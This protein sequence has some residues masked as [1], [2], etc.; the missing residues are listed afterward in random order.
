MNSSSRTKKPVVLTN[1]SSASS[2]DISGALS[3][4]FERYGYERPEQFV[5]Q[6]ADMGAMMDEMRAAKGDLLVSYG[7]DGTAAAVASIARE[8]NLPFIA[9]PGGTM[10]MLMLGLYG[11]DIW[12]ECLLRAL[13][14][15][16]PRPMTVGV[17]RDEQGQTGTFMVGAMFGKPT[18]MSAA[19][20]DLRDGNVV[21]AAKGA[22]DALKATS[23]GVAIDIARQGS[24]YENRALELI[25]VTCPFMDGEAL[26]PERLDLTLF[27]TI[28]GGS[29]LSLGFSA[30]RGNLRHSQVVETMKSPKFRLRAGGTID[31]LLDG[32]PY[33]FDG[34]VSVEIDPAHGLVLAPWPAMASQTPTR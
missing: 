4:I 27:E 8:Q 28:T 25:N 21:E 32:E 24:D 12:E 16:K 20:E 7:G 33:I 1:L 17:V 34:D 15:A 13:A 30:L 5:G 23:D 9:L 6:S 11:S 2:E 14:C 22:M 10:N 26:D 31:A 19:R 18:Q 3:S 29:A